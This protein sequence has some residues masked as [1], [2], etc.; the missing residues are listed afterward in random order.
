MS[1]FPETFQQE[2]ARF[3]ARF[4][5]NLLGVVEIGSFAH[6]EAIRFSDHDLR[7]IVRCDV[8]LLVF[9]EHQWT[10]ESINAAVTVID[11]QDLNQC[12]DL[13]FGL[14]NLAYVE[15]MLANGRYPLIDHTCLYQG[16]ILVDDT[17]ELMVRAFSWR[18][19]G[20]R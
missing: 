19:W 14:T 1:E 5:V 12:P 11:W 17:G 10:E 18:I 16:S 13:T 15:Q 6:G 3:Q 4:G 9:N 7:L 8:P 20:M 2:Y